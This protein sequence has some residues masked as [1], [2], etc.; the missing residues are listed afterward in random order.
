MT[1]WKPGA[2]VHQ[3]AGV[4]VVQLDASSWARSGAQACRPAVDGDLHEPHE[5]EITGAPVVPEAASAAKP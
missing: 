5:M 1:H 2:G 3:S 4:F